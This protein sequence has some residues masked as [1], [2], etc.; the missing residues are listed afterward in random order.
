MFEFLK[1]RKIKLQYF[2]ITYM[3]ISLLA[4]CL[5]FVGFAV[6]FLKINLDEVDNLRFVWMTI[7]H[8]AV[9]VGKEL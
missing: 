4:F 1:V 5:F 8:L 6:F 2:I 9:H 7:V 3:R